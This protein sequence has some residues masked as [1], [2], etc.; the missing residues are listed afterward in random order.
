MLSWGIKTLIESTAR[1]DHADKVDPS[2][3]DTWLVHAENNE[4]LNWL[5]FKFGIPESPAMDPNSDANL[6]L[7]VGRNLRG[8]AIRVIV[9][10]YPTARWSE[11]LPKELQKFNFKNLGMF[12]GDFIDPKDAQKTF[13][14]FREISKL[15]VFMDDARGIA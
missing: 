8:Q 12:K 10:R 9:S 14:A 2:D 11:R 15:P 4:A 7:S 3:I 5:N 13:Q 6:L 1:K